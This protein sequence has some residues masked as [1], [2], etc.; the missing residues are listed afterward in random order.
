MILAGDYIPK[1][2]R[3]DWRLPS[4]TVLCNLEAP[5][6]GDA[7]E[8]F[9]PS[10]KAGPNLYNVT[11]GNER[12]EFAFNLANN[13][14]MDYGPEGMRATLAMLSARG[15]PCC[16]AGETREA[17]RMPMF[18]LESGREIAV[19]G[20]CEHQFGVSYGG[21]PGVA[22][23]GGWV[24]DAVRAAR[25]R[26]DFVVVSCH[27]ALESSPFPDPELRLFYHRLIDEG[28]S[29]IHGHHAHV[30]QGWE[31]YG[32][33]VIFY[34]MGN[35]VVDPACWGN[36]EPY[37][38]SVAAA[39]DF[40]GRKLQWRTFLTRVEKSGP[41]TILIR[42]CTPEE[43]AERQEYLAICARALRD[44][45]AVIGYFQEGEL[46]HFDRLYGIP[47]RLPAAQPVRL[48]LRN[49]IRYAVELLADAWA[50]VSGRKLCSR[51][52]RNRARIPFNFF[53]CESH[54]RAVA[55]ALGVQIGEYPDLRTSR[56]AEDAARIMVELL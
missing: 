36:V 42:E 40:S 31:Q 14:M 30:P 18:L 52:T 53:Q 22:A 9:R 12:R 13:H 7:P 38:W 50:V 45:N 15:I 47:L 41:Q 43:Q 25:K 46:R 26:A 19:I 4:G 39:V 28:A 10:P 55:V 48:T 54:S 34:G 17:A 24:F 21:R 44:E 51:R 3:V 16:G 8:R 29:V 37:C 23:L 5:V 27:A 1:G 6:L 2:C 35:F 56:T 49:R 33:G 20:C 32:E 11:L